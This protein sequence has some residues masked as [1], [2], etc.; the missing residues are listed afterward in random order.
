[1]KPIIQPALHR[2]R[3]AVAVMTGLLLVLVLVPMGGLVIDM[4]HLYIAKAELQNAADAAALAAAKDLNSKD[5]GI[6][7]AIA[8][9]IAVAGKHKYDFT[10]SLT[11]QA[12]DFVFANNPD[13]PWYTQ[14]QAKAAPAGLTFVKADTGSKTMPT[15]LMGIAGVASTS[16]NG[17]AVAGRYVNVVTPIGICAVDPANRTAQYTYPSGLTEL[18]EFGFRRGVGYNLFDLGKLGGAPSDPYLINP[19]DTP[20][21]CDANNSSTNS[22]AP[23]ICNGNSAVITLGSGQVN[24]NT[25]LS[26]TIEKALNSRFDDFGGGSKCDAAQ[27]PPDVNVKEYPTSAVNWQGSPPTRETV[28]VTNST[29][30]YSLP[31]AT[32]PN[33]G[34][35]TNSDYGVLWAYGPSY[36]SN[37]ASPPAVGNPI[38]TAEA[39]ANSA[40]YSSAS[41]FNGNYPSSVGNGFSA[42][43]YQPAP[44]NQ[45]S[46]AYFQAPTHTGVADRRVLNLVLVDCRSAPVGNAS[47][48]VMSAVGIGRFF[49]LRRADFT[50]GTKHLDVEFEGLIEPVPDA[51]VRLYR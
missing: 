4:G 26:A 3:G 22:T 10:T 35:I 5:T 25:G 31:P 38:T 41:A 23:F 2:Q 14:A 43:D 11:M 8:S 34:G 50:G 17:V 19:V 44:Y 45:S 40:M 1:M 42:T 24:T 46:V 51:A 28:S 7:A 30:K 27:A 32:V 47:C 21:A 48:G 39:N 36:R 49:M 37:G 20:P 15:I 9:G 6:D 18:V 29:P 13:G 12:S 33:T 16:T